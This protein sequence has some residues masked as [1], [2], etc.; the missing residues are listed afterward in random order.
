[1]ETENGQNNKVSF[2]KKPWVQSLIGVVV[3]F[4]LLGGFIFWQTTKNTVL[5]ENS[6][7][8]APVVNLS[9]SI[10]GILNALYVKE[11]DRISANSEVALVG[12]QI[13]YA[14]ADGIVGSAPQVVGTYFSPGQTVVSIIN[15]SQMRVVGA[16]D[17]TKGLKDIAVGQRATF[18]VDAFPGRTFEGAVVEISPTANNTSVVFSISDKRPV[19]NFNV[20]VNYDVAKYPELKNGMSA[21]ITV[22]TK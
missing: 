14:K 10:P 8:V 12:S 20:K 15:M 6:Y 9:P 16:I 4:G 7:L 5:V 2:I 13:I 21:K 17:E 3:I 19:E 22:H 1:M 11:G 18:T